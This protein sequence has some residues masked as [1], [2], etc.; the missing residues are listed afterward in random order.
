[1]KVTEKTMLVKWSEQI[2]RNVIVLFIF[3][4]EI[5][6]KQCLSTW[7]AFD[8][9]ASLPKFINLPINKNLFSVSIVQLQHFTF[10][11][12]T[13]REL[14]NSAPYITRRRGG[15][16]RNQWYLSIQP[17]RKKMKSPAHRRASLHAPTKK[18]LETNCQ[19]TW[20]DLRSTCSP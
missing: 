10:H 11:F 12:P 14:L 9:A 19:L 2:E 16:G 7:I 13:N 17:A 20:I 15:Q 3:V 4:F 6:R 18:T 1:M 8:E 5:G